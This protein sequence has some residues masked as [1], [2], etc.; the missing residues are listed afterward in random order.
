M[1]R[2]FIRRSNDVTYFT[3][4]AARELDTLREGG[5]GWWLRGRGDTRDARD[6]ERVFTTTDRSTVVGY[7]VVVAAPRPVSILVAIDP[8]QAAQV[9]AAHRASVAATMHY[10]EE[11]ALVVRDRRRG[12]DREVAATWPRVV[13]FTHGL[14]RH[15]EPHLHDHVLV[16]A[17]PDGARSVLDS[18]ALFAHA[19]AADALYRSS[20]RYELAA[21]TTWTAWRSFKGIDH[22]E[23]LDEGYRA[24]WGGHHR[25]RGEKLNWQRGETVE[26]WRRDLAGFT[27]EGAPSSPERGRTELDEHVFGATLEGRRDVARRHVVEAWSHAATFGQAPRETGASIDDLYPTLRDSRGVREATVG[28]TQARMIAAVRERGARPLAPDELARWVQ[29]SRER[30][31][32]W[33]ERSR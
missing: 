22:V 14:N 21:R 3:N 4:D 19:R 24:L 11:R 31:G 33:S 16:G 9:V 8:A 26:R 32:A 7:D 28:V 13:S 27:S 12:E 15:G 20:L 1:L 10:L 25:G 6:V 17:R 18:R 30:S 29:R 2:L 23:G 5:P